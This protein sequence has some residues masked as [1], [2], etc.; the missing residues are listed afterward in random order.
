MR[1]TSSSCGHD[2]PPKMDYSLETRAKIIPLMF[3]W[4]LSGTFIT[5]KE[6]KTEIGCWKVPDKLDRMVLGLWN[7]ILGGMWKSLGLGARKALKCYKKSLMRH[8]GGNLENIHVQR[9]VDNGGPATEASKG[10]KESIMKD[11]CRQRL[12]VHFPLNQTKI[13]TLKL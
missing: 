13:I 3:T 9:N 8:S 2:T 5:G 12:L 4:L 6:T 7:W 11:G 10:K 1:I